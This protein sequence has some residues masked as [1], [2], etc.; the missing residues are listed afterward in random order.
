VKLRKVSIF[1]ALLAVVAL[2]AGCMKVEASIVLQEDDTASGHMIFA[3]DKEVMD[4][5]GGEADD[6]LGELSE[7]APPGSTVEPYE[8]DQYIGQRFDFQDEP[9]E[10]AAGGDLSITRD[11]DH[12]V[13]AGELDLSMEETGGIEDEF[14]DSMDVRYAITFPGEVLEHDGELDGT[15]VIWQAVPGSVTPINAVGV[16]TGTGQ[17]PA[18]LGEGGSGEDPIDPEEPGAEDDI[19]EE[20][21]PEEPETGEESDE[22]ID[23]ITAE[24]EDTD[25]GG[26]PLWLWIVLGIVGLL[27]IAIIILIIV[28][29]SRKKKGDD[30]GY[31]GGG[32]PHDPYGPQGQYGA[33]Q[34]GGYPQ[35]GEY[36][37]QGGHPQQSGSPYQQQQPGPYQQQG[38]PS[39]YGAP[40]PGAPAPGGPAPE[41]PTQPFS[42]APPAPGQPGGQQGQP[43]D[44]YGGQQQSGQPTQQQPSQPGQPD[45]PGGQQPPQ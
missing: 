21:T 36:P 15:T 23:G 17:P 42:P 24:A 1:A 12:F 4:M 18:D 35:Q 39:P 8:D 9:M 10:G 2:V 44:Q 5:M 28:V 29:A 13:V 43:G 27:V 7:D 34:Q 30:D 41:A 31:P 19:G 37:Q 3:F 38:A 45:Q 25:E 26:I 16:A 32:A 6:I 20:E 14:L 11:G 40:A 33:Q 22:D